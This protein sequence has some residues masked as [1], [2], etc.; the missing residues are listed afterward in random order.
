LRWK[1]LL[2]ASLVA[3]LLG[4]GGSYILF[5]V[6]RHFNVINLRSIN[7]KLAFFELLPLIMSLGSGIFVYRHTARR[8]KFQAILTIILSLIVSQLLMYFAVPLLSS[9][10]ARRLRG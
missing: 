8:R 6:L 1:L 2:I 10:L 4:A 9:L 3:A 7:A 5:D